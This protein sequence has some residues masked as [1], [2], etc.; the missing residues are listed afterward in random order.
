MTITGMG[1]PPLLVNA[2]DV[3]SLENEYVELIPDYCAHR[4]PLKEGGKVFA[5]GSLALNDFRA[6]LIERR[7]YEGLKKIAKYRLPPDVAMQAQQQAQQQAQF[8]QQ[9]QQQA[10]SLVQARVQSQ[11]LPT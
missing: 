11:G 4:L 7:R 9:S 2:A 1:E 10:Q 3:M 6:K 8:Q 5:D